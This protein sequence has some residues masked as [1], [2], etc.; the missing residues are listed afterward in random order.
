M[1]LIDKKNMLPKDYMITIK[2]CS[3]LF[4]QLFIRIKNLQ[5]LVMD[6]FKLIHKFKIIMRELSYIRY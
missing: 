3:N 2:K 6:I 5:Q 4:L 1:P